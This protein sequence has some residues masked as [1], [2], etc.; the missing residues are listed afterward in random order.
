MRLSVI[1]WFFFDENRRWKKNYSEKSCWHSY[2]FRGHLILIINHRCVENAVCFKH[3]VILSR[4]GKVFHLIVNQSLLARKKRRSLVCWCRLKKFQV[5]EAIDTTRHD[6]THKREHT[7]DTK[8]KSFDENGPWT[9]FLWLSLLLV[10]FH[11]F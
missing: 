8:R 9:S 3:C 6:P 1:N 5:N 7:F 10:K 2:I 11:K 4:N